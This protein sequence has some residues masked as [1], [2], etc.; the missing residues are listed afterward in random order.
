VIARKLQMDT[1]VIIIQCLQ[2]AVFKDLI[3]G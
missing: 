3:R 1:Q 2:V